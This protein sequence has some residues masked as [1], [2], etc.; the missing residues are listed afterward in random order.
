MEL[1]YL[2]E[3]G[4]MTTSSKLENKFGISA[5]WIRLIKPS[6][7]EIET[8][9]KYTK[10]PK[11]E[12]LDFLEDEERSRVEQGKYLQIIYR[13]PFADKK[14]IRTI[15][16]CVFFANHTFVT[17]ERENIYVLEQL[18]SRLRAG[19]F[20]LLFRKS[21]GFFVYNIFDKINDE[22]QK[23]VTHIA[24]V[25]RRSEREYSK[26]SEKQ[27]LE[28]YSSNVALSHFSQALIANRDVLAILRKSRLR[29]FNPTDLE[30]FDDLY[31]DL[32][33][34]IDTQKIEMDIMSKMFNFQTILS[35]YRLN[36]FMK[37]ITALA[38]I[39][40]VPTLISSIYGMNVA[41]P[42]DKN[43]YAFWGLMLFMIGLSFLGYI[44][45][46]KNEWI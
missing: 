24:S 25:I 29:V 40:A 37:R 28:I 34:I 22:F 38:L 8:V 11:E 12:F 21:A 23:S 41:L 30:R 42:F 46:A 44:Y 31:H 39:I 4:E 45:M 43:P 17:I 19:R 33:Q 27:L 6:E 18:A 16:F 15:S 35:S 20:K 32:L 7:E 5:T 36:T 13:T 14:E 26:S 2:N 10:I 3:K 9:S 1:F